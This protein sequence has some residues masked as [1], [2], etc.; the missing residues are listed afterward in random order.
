MCPKQ[1]YAREWLAEPLAAKMRPNCHKLSELE[2][3]VIIRYKIDT[4]SRGFGPR[5]AGVED[6]ANFILES[7]GGKRVGGRWV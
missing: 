1:H 6:M 4:D 7:R 3:Q 2:K 5:L